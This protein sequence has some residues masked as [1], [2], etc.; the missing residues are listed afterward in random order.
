MNIGE[1]RHKLTFQEPTEGRDAMGGITTTWPEKDWLTVWAAIWPMKDKELAES[2]KLQGR[3][4]RRIRVRYRSDL[5]KKHRIHWAL[6]FMLAC[7]VIVLLLSAV[8]E[9]SIARTIITA[10]VLI[11]SITPFIYRLC[12]SVKAGAALRKSCQ[13]ATDD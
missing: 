10:I 9:M 7:M 12:R 4:V 3:M 11:A 13:E 2:M 1:M 5:H 6:G 8:G